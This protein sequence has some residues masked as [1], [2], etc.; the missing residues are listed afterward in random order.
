M[1]LILMKSLWSLE[2]SESNSNSK[3]KGTNFCEVSS[4][5]LFTLVFIFHSV[6]PY[7]YKPLAR[8]EYL[9]NA[10]FQKICFHEILL[11]PSRNSTGIILYTFITD[12]LYYIYWT[13]MPESPA[14]E[15]QMSCQH[16]RDF[17]TGLLLLEIEP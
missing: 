10:G 6:L 16:R 3:Y 1:E 4:L 5:L 13:N 15:I 12:L 14:I 9:K 2:H 17:W 11:S 8:C 7:F